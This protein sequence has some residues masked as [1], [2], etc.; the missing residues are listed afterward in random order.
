VYADLSRQLHVIDPDG[1]ELLMSVGAAVFNLR[2]AL[3]NHGRRPI[4][5]LLPGGSVHLAARVTAGPAVVPSHTARVLAAAVPRRHTNRLPY[6]RTPIPADVLDELRASAASEGAHLHLLDPASRNAVFALAVA[7]RRMELDRAYRRELAAWTHDEPGRRDG[8]PPSTVGPRDATGQLPLRDF[9][10]GASAR[11]VPFE[12]HPQ[13]AVLTTVGDGAWQWL[14]AGQA[15]QR[16][17]LTATLR[18]LSA[19]PITQ[20][21]ETPPLRRLVVGTEGGCFAQAII[22]LGFGDAAAAAPR[23]PLD[24][25]LA[26]PG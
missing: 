5:R 17:L 2:V 1:R 8:I 13:I 14:R 24:E 26:T 7:A 4:T 10:P 18:G 22:R 3:L 23:R 19:Q 6:A 9:T 21:L 16:M 20:P 25:V 15:L 12:P 11:A